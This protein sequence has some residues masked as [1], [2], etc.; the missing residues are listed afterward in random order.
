[1]NDLWSFQTLTMTWTEHKTTGAVPSLRSNCTIHYDAVARRVVVFGGG[2][3][4]KRRFNAVSLLDWDTKVWT[5][6]HPRENEAAPWERTY[7]TSEIIYPYLMVYGGEGA[8]DL[9]DL[10]AFHL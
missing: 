2:G 4:N 6:I 10:W 3:S 9:D 5:E 7:H 8:A 1:M